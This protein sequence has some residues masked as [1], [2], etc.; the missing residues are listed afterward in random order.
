MKTKTI[1]KILRG[2]FANFLKSIKDD[3]VRKLVKDNSIITGGAIV[4]L[5]LN[6]DVNDFDLYFTNRETVIAVCNYYLDLL[7]KNHKDES[8]LSK[9]HVQKDDDGRI[10]VYLPSSDIG[11]IKKPEG[12]KFYPQLITDNA[13]SLSNDT[14]LIIRFYDTPEEIHK[15][16]DF[17]H[18]KS[19]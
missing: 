18:V 10:K 4:S 8:I 5:V 12:E 13:I 16:Y 1:E 14:Q 2:Q 19:Y 17:V 11:N 7:K 9:A 3:N 6:E 15:N